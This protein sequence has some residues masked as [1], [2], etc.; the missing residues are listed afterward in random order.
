[1]ERK[2]NDWWFIAQEDPPTKDSVR[3]EARTQELWGYDAGLK[4]F[5]RIIATIEGRLF[6]FTSSGW[7]VSN[8]SEIVWDGSQRDEFGQKW[9]WRKVVI[10]KTATEFEVMNYLLL[11]SEGAPSWRQDSIERCRK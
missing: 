9:R 1:M 6:N 8:P 10:K 7:Q 2:L 4:Q 3:I 11:D 5:T